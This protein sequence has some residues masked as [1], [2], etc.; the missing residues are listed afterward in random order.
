MST[1]TPERH[2]AI[3]PARLPPRRR[4]R[5]EH[6]RTGEAL[7]EVRTALAISLAAT[8]VA[9]FALGVV[10]GRVTRL[11]LVRSGIQVLV[12]GGASAGIG[13]LIGAVV[14]A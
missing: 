3:Q 10:K 6:P 1:A 8:G 5:G 14:P 2:S 4:E 11:A 7:W 12:I 13:Y 9:L